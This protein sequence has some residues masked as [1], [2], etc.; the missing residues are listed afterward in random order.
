MA[1]DPSE[2]TLRLT[3]LGICVSDLE[4]SVAFYVEALGFVEAQRLAFDDAATARI[5][6]VVSVDVDLVYLERDGFRVEL[7]AY[8]EPE[9]DGSGIVRPMTR[10]GFTHLSLLVDDLDRVGAAIAAAG[11]S[12]LSDTAVTFRWGN[13]GVMAT[14]PDGNRIELIEARPVDSS[15]AI[16]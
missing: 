7:L 10:T 9:V 3:H 15:D 12:I 8:R 6:G 13:R 16:R 11:G 5:L 2:P 1:T 4:R 14:D